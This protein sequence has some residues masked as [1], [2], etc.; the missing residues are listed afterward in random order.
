MKAY[1]GVKVWQVHAF[2]TPELWKWQ[3]RFTQEEL[4]T[5]ERSLWPLLR[6]ERWSHIPA[7]SPIVAVTTLITDDVIL[8]ILTA[9]HASQQHVNCST[10]L[11]SRNQY[12]WLVL[13]GCNGVNFLKYILSPMT[14]LWVIPYQINMEQIMCAVCHHLQDRRVS[15]AYWPFMNIQKWCIICVWVGYTST[16]M[17]TLWL[18]RGL[19]IRNECHNTEKNIQCTCCWTLAIQLHRAYY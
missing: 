17:F 2:L 5:Q 8:V 3:V 7:C 18:A 19:Q 4:N 14:C 12:Y 6:S 15:L 10:A 16:I 9:V 11:H 1:D 13:L